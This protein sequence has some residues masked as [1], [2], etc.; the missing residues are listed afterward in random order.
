MRRETLL[1]FFEDVAG[2]DEIF[3]VHDDGYR[4]RQVT[5]RELAAQAAA[6]AQRLV[7]HGIGA[8][9]KVVFWSENRIEWIAA[10]WGCVQLGTVVVPVDFRASEDLL[11]RI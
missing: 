2:S 9:D 3:I 5:Y 1:D 10:F 11:H 6:F 4:V 8:D 7:A